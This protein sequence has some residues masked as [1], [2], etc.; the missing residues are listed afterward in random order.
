MFIPYDLEEFKQK[1]GLNFSYNDY[2]PGPKISSQKE[3]IEWLNKF[4]NG[5]D[6]YIKERKKMKDLVHTYQDGKSCKRVANLI[7]K[8][9]QKL[10]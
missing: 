2:T 7:N 10:T 9:L 4:R 1:R 3:L 8:M 6:P 5:D